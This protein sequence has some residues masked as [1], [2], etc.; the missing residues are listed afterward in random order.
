MDTSPRRA[1][2]SAATVGRIMDARERGTAF[3]SPGPGIFR[4]LKTGMAIIFG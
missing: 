3:S 2:I 4:Q 1:E